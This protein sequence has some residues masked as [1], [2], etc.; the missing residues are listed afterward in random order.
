M[1]FVG[2]IIL[3]VLLLILFHLQKKPSKKIIGGCAGTRYGCCPNTS[4]PKQNM[5]GTNCLLKENMGNTCFDNCMDNC[6]AMYVGCPDI[7]LQQCQ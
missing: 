1:Y 7:C 3:L 2:I 6:P 4:I 5:M